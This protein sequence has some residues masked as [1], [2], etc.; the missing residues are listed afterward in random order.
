MPTISEVRV[1]NVEIPLTTVFST[2]N[3]TTTASRLLLV[4]LRADG[5]EGWGEAPLNITFTG[6]TPASARAAV[7]R[8]AA[9]SVLGRDAEAVA[10]SL[11]E[12]GGRLG[13]LIG[14]RCALS[15][16]LWDLRG[17]M[18]GVPL[19]RLLGGARRTA[20]PVVYHL[21]HFD[22]DQ[23]AHDAQVATDAGFRIL[24]LKVGRDDVAADL[25]AVERVREAAGPHT[26]IYVDANQAWGR[27]QAAA[28]ARHAPELG[29]GVIEQPVSR[30]DLAGLA[31]LS[32]T[33]GVV[34]AADES[35]Y[36]PAQLLSALTAGT[37]PGGVVVKLLKA[38]GIEGAR[39]LLDLCHLAGVQPFLAGMCGDSSIGSAALLHVAAAAPE[40]PLGTAITPHFSRTDVVAEPLEVKDGQLHLEAVDSPGLGVEVDRAAVE[41]LDISE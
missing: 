38:G 19:H 12:I 24:K 27:A 37:T 21:G 17:R 6:E 5:V 31:Q 23:D 3:K 36:D 33:P 4:N 25:R 11:P 41:A 32:A 26:R 20:V 18:L 14:A 15:M 29:V 30:W 35:V 40:L 16:A 22:D 39:A 10:A 34:V 2:S 7:E 9:E 8:T 13:G 28:F 1:Y